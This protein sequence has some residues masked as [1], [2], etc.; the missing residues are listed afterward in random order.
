MFDNV[1]RMLRGTSGFIKFGNYQHGI[2]T[3]YLIRNKCL[4]PSYM[5]SKMAQPLREKIENQIVNLLCFCF[6]C[7]KTF[8]SNYNLKQHF[9]TCP[10]HKYP[11]YSF[12]ELKNKFLTYEVKEEFTKVLEQYKDLS[13]EKALKLSFE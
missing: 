2:F 5:L 11:M 6:F 7:H 13:L 1:Y 4:A 8:R 12:K 3:G 9:L 10:K